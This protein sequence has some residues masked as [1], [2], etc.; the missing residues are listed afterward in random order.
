MPNRRRSLGPSTEGFRLPSPAC[1]LGTADH[2]R[3]DHQGR[4]TLA[5]ARSGRYR[6]SG[7]RVYREGRRRV[8]TA[9]SWAESLPEAARS[10]H[11]TTF[12]AIGGSS[13]RW[14]RIARS[15]STLRS[16]TFIL[17]TSGHTNCSRS[18]ACIPAAEPERKARSAA[19]WLLNQATSTRSGTTASSVRAVRRFMGAFFLELFCRRERVAPGREVGAQI[20]GL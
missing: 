9:P 19:Q 5:E 17:S 7:A 6:A 12:S 14:Q 8:R 15:A 20:A 11:R 1:E 18:R 2:C 10:R 16:S 13:C 3:T 4:T